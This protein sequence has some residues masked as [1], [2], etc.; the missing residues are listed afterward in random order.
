FFT[1]KGALSVYA[2][3]LAMTARL[4]RNGPADFSGTWRALVAANPVEMA[5]AP[6]KPTVNKTEPALSRGAMALPSLTPAPISVASKPTMAAAAGAA[7]S[8][9]GLPAVVEDQGAAALDDSQD[10]AVGTGR[11]T[12]AHL[13]ADR[14]LAQYFSLASEAERRRRKE[15]EDGFNA[16]MEE[17]WATLNRNLAAYYSRRTTIA[18]A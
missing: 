8:L 14:R 4:Y 12:P 5:V 2:A 13:D 11:T 1:S 17:F 10:E 6:I 9:P 7:D 15:H 18:T 3:W 16:S